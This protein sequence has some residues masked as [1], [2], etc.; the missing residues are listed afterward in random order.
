MIDFAHMAPVI[1]DA[2]L[3]EGFVRVIMPDGKCFDILEE[4]WTK[5]RQI[6]PGCV[7]MSL[8]ATGKNRN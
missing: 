5:A 2:E 3:Q 1:P 7:I 6:E 4:L 8:K